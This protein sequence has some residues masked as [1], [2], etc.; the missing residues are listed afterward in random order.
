M[1]RNEITINGISRLLDQLEAQEPFYWR[2]CWRRRAT[3]GDIQ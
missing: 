1:K 3:R 2:S